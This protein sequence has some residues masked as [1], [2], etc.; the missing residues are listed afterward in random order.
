M[1]IIISP[2]KKMNEDTDS[3]EITGMPGFINDAKILM[4]EMKSMS[5]SEGKKLWKCNDKLAEL[6]HKRY[7]DMTLVHRLTPA[8]IAYEG[9]SISIWLRRCLQAEHFRTYQ[10]ICGYCQASMEY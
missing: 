1:K 4:H 7:K 6:N 10:I 3:I 8:V 2:A 5:L 9:C